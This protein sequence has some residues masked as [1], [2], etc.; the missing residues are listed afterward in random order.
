MFDTPPSFARNP[1]LSR[2]LR[3]VLLAA[4]LLT[5]E[6]AVANADNLSYPAVLEPP[7]AIAPGDQ[8]AAGYHLSLASDRPS[9]FITVRDSRIG[10]LA[11]CPDGSTTP[12]FMALDDA[13]LVTPPF[14]TD[15]VPGDP[16][17]DVHDPAVYQSQIVAPDV[18]Q[19]QAY[20]S[21]ASILVLG[22]LD[23]S[24]MTDVAIRAQFH[25]VNATSNPSLS[26]VWSPVATIRPVK[27][28]PTPTSTPTPTMTPTPNPTS[29]PQPTSTATPTDT[30][31]PTSTATVDPTATVASTATPS[32]T[33]LATTTP[34]ATS[35]VAAP[36]ITP[37]PTNTPVALI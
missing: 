16:A 22:D 23:A 31:S 14:S 13:A 21:H 28:T 32:P 9:V 15:W 20:V 1:F 25:L 29:T 17:G 27:P 7:L 11:R 19:G 3:A 18:C 30:P 35:T 33:P 8:L 12:V 34:L 10:L 37:L 6:Y 26:G 36:T 5:T 24:D 4:C 2:I